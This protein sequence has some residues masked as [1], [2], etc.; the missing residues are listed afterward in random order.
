[1]LDKQRARIWEGGKAVKKSNSIE[2]VIFTIQE[3]IHT[4]LVI[5]PFLQ[6]VGCKVAAEK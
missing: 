2:V 1:V 6:G 4:Y 3:T 5:Y